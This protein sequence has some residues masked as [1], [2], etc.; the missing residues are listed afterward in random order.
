MNS[1]TVQGLAQKYGVT[2]PAMKISTVESTPN[3]SAFL[4]RL[5]TPME[6]ISTNELRGAMLVLD[7]AVGGAVPRL[8][9]KSERL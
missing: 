4:L 9:P 3:P 5:D 8:V 7:A 6:G 2:P 1:K